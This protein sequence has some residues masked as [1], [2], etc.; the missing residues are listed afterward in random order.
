MSELSEIKGKLSEI[1]AVNAVMFKNV[2]DQQDA[3]LKS[4]D[5][6][7]E[8]VKGLNNSVVRRDA[9]GDLVKVWGP[10]IASVISIVI[11][12]VVLVVYHQPQ[13]TAKEIQSRLA[14]VERKIETVVYT[15]GVKNEDSSRKD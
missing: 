2:N 12:L 11:T 9:Q 5:G 7:R 3:I 14:E 6:L 13:A 4:V 15:G 10:Y 1:E 8:E